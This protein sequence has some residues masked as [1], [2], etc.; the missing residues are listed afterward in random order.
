M[1]HIEMG[2]KILFEGDS[3]TDANRD[4]SNRHSLT[5]YNAIVGH[6]IDV[7][8]CYN[9]GVS[10]SRTKDLAK[11]LEDSISDTRPDYVSILIGINDVWRKYDSN[12]PTSDEAFTANYERIL[13]I[14]TRRTRGVIILEPYL[15]PILPERE[16]FREEL[17]PKIDIVRRLARKYHVGAYVPLNGL[18]AEAAVWG[19]P[20]DY[21]LD[22]I[23]P[24]AGGH[25]FIAGEFFKRVRIDY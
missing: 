25:T 2:A 13:N 21:S 9:R 14:A 1:L 4:R 8:R 20:T 19:S 18:F 23:H 10:G 24:N 6:R 17:N 12:D 3:I 15:I 5:G 16:I 11:R 7:E 22:G